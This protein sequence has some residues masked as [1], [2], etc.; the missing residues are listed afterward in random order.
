MKLLLCQTGDENVICE[1]NTRDIFLR[2]QKSIKTSPLRFPLHANMSYLYSYGVQ[3]GGMGLGNDEITHGASFKAYNW[4]KM[5]LRVNKNCPVT[6]F[7]LFSFSE[8]Q[9]DHQ[10]QNH[11]AA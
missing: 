10:S 5:H 8:P 7:C 3:R 2:R 1:I 11:D 4:Q 9:R 6:D